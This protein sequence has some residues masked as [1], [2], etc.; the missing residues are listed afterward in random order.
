[1]IVIEPATLPAA[2]A[3]LPGTSPLRARLIRKRELTRFL[4]LAA[5]AAGVKGQISVL[6]TDDAT[7]RGLNLRFRRKNKATVVL[8]F[9]AGEPVGKAAFLGGDL[10]ISLET[11][12]R[13]AKSFEHTLET[14]VKVLLL[15]GV[16]HLAGSDHD[17]DAGQMARREGA[18]R[19]RF[20]LPLGLIQRSGKTDAAK[21]SRKPVNRPASNPKR[22]ARP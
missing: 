14:E 2:L 5:E 21:R 16:L 9:P 11:A 4:A 3:A 8:S 20:E 18:L 10:A 19:K 7:I 17:T 12:A 22:G 13:Q 1:M 15:H 6:L